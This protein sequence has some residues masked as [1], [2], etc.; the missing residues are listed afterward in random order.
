MKILFIS[1]YYPPEM[2]ALASRA[3]EMCRMW[4]DSNH[5]V[6]VLTA[7]PNYPSGIIPAEYKGMKWKTEK[8]NGVNI[9]RTYIHA[10]HYKGKLNRVL[11]YISFLFSGI[12]WGRKLIGRPDVI[13]ASS[14]PI[15]VPV[16]GYFLSKIKKTPLVFEVRDL[17]PES[18]IQISNVNNRL[19]LGILKKLELFLYLKARMIIVVTES[20]KTFITDLGIEGDKIEIVK[21]GVDLELYNPDKINTFPES[22]AHLKDKF[23]VSYIGNH[24]M[25]QGLSTIIQVAEKYIAQKEIH[26]LFV[27]DGAEK[28]MLE[29]KVHE[30]NLSNVTFTGQIDKQQMPDYYAASNVV[31]V[32]LKNLPLFQKVIPS[33]IFEIMAMEK[34]MIIS[35]PG[36]VK[37]IVVDEAQAGLFAEPENVNKIHEAILELYNSDEKRKTMGKNGRSFVN[38]NYS[39]KNLADKYI[40]YLSKMGR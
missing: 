1:Q 19:I 9:I 22:I 14:P 29:Q 34:A 23:I 40:G 16:I 27:G 37:H 38:K 8:V 20:F 33:K 13:I 36:E 39:R 17:W 18:I 26:F 3:S 30:L 7:F 15:L 2:G 5:E 6:S 10:G 35:V 31:L 11:N 4:S 25:A 12:F 28:P 32:P 21:N 24:G